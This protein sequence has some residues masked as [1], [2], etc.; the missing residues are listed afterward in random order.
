M[1]R[2]SK[3]SKNSFNKV[4]FT[5]VVIMWFLKVGSTVGI[6]PVRWNTDTQKLTIISQSSQLKIQLTCLVLKLNAYNCWVVY[7]ILLIMT[8][9]G[10]V[11]FILFFLNMEQVSSVERVVSCL[12]VALISIGVL[13]HLSCIWTAESAAAQVNL[14]VNFNNRASKR[15]RILGL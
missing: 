11:A 14:L 1:D 4:E 13:V 10:Y 15:S 12:Y 9:V 5:K 3:L 6:Y 2:F 8:R 7:Y